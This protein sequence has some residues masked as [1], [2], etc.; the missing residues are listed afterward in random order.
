MI[1][2]LLDIQNNNI[3]LNILNNNSFYLACIHNNLEVI[4]FLLNIPNNNININETEE[5]ILTDV[6]HIGNV[7][8]IDFL[9]TRQNNNID[10]NKNNSMLFRKACFSNNVNVAKTLCKYDENYVVEITNNVII[11]WHVKETFEM[12]K[13]NKD[14]EECPICMDTNSEIITECNHQL[15]SHCYYKMKTTTNICHICR[16]NI[17]KYFS[18]EI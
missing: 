14:I 18:I 9:L 8:I 1:K 2:Y 15:C 5:S 16:H 3:N 4:K 10:I 6:C 11:H 7:D 17:T 13:I 12:K